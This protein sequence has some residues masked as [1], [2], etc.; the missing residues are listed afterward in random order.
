[1][2]EIPRTITFFGPDG[3]GKSS[4]ANEYAS[5]LRSEH[6]A[7]VSVIGGA[8]FREWLSPE[9]SKE[10]LGTE[11]NP[12]ALSQT[13]TGKDELY[14]SI[15]IACYGYASYLKNNGTY[16]VID[17]D[18]Y[19]KRMIWARMERNRAE[20][21]TYEGNFE[22]NVTEH[23]GAKTFPDTVVGVNLGLDGKYSL[24]EDYFKRIINRGQ[25]DEYDPSNL[26][27]AMRIANHTLEIWNEVI[28]SKKYSRLNDAAIATLDNETDTSLDITKKIKQVAGLLLSKLS[29]V[30]SL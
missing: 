11:I 25:V 3:C 2:A 15:A 29:V 20:Y 4:I 18:P 12:D 8:S 13:S 10:F 7:D 9:I 1:M 5:L 26:D 19:L 16:V 14:E 22:N 24:S 30:E 6:G 28:L 21:T 23:I 17:S 27:E